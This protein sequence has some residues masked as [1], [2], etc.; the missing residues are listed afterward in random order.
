MVP[1]FPET[2]ARVD[3]ADE[4]SSQMGAE[5]MDLRKIAFRVSVN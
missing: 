3:F 1:V 5:E 4:A 2:K